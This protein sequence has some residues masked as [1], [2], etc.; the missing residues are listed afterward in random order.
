[1]IQY[2]IEK[3]GISTISISHLGHLTKKVRVPRALQ[4]KFPL[5]RSFGKA[6]EIEMQRKILVDCLYYLKEMTEPET[7]VKLPYKWKGRSKR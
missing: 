5:G 6:G 4:I 2:A 7:M 1:M 3:A